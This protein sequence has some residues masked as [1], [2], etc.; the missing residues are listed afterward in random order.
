MSEMI[1]AAR[2]QPVLGRADAKARNT[3]EAARAI[4]LAETSARESK[5]AKLRAARLAMEAAKAEAGPAPAAKS[6]RA[7][8]PRR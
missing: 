8:K 6:T 5:T 3:S 7:R 2:P 4:M 1:S